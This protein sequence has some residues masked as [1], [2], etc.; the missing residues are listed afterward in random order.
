MT[1]R[2]WVLLRRAQILYQFRIEQLLVAP[3]P[4]L[5]IVRQHAPRGANLG[6]RAPIAAEATRQGAAAGRT[7]WGTPK[8]S[9]GAR[10]PRDQ[11]SDSRGPTGIRHGRGTATRRANRPEQDRVSP[12]TPTRAGEGQGGRG[13]PRERRRAPKRRRPGGQKKYF[14]TKEGLCKKVSSRLGSTWVAPV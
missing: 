12:K 1:M 4:N 7:R 5:R 10:K 8:A 13:G 9:T 11:G 6:A 14:F 2:T 3:N